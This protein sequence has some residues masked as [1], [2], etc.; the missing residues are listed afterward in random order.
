MFVYVIL[1]NETRFFNNMF[2]I[3]FNNNSGIDD[4]KLW[5]IRRV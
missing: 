5:Q 1:D 2:R 4:W 3:I